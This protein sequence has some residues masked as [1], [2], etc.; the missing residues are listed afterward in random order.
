MALPYKYKG[1]LGEPR[2]VRLPLGYWLDPANKEYE[3]KA[4]A[5]Y[6]AQEE[7]YI[8]ALFLDCDVPRDDHHG[9]RHVAMT[10][11]KR[12]VKGFQSAITK[13]MGRAPKRP[14]DEEFALLEEMQALIWAGQSIRNA[15]RLVASKHRG[16]LTAGGLDSTYRRFVRQGKAAEA[17]LK[18]M[19]QA[20]RQKSPK[21][22][23]VKR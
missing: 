3:A 19:L 22:S 17:E 5:M 14:P 9:W 1:I 10:L 6:E 4:I 2:P 7:T 12:H 15:A 16:K 18:N 23:A 11:A 13:R 20:S 21:T 8:D